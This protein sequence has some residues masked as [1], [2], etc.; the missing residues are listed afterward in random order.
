MCVN[1]KKH[2]KLN[3]FQLTAKNIQTNVYGCSSYH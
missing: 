2:L 3:L 1:K